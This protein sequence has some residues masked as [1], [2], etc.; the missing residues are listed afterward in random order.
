MRAVTFQGPREVAVTDVPEP[1]VEEPDDVVVET[2]LT[3]VCGSDLHLYHGDLPMEDGQVMGHE[4][5]GRVLEAGPEARGF[6]EGD[7]VVASF[8]VPCGA[9]PACRIGEHQAC[10]KLRLFGLGKPNG[11]LQGVQ[12][13]RVRVPRANLA[14]HHLP[15]GLPWHAGIFACDTLTAAYTG[16]RPRLRPGSTVA[17]VGAGPVGL[18]SLEVARALGAGATIAV[19]I[20][21]ARL[22]IAASRGHATV[23]PGHED[24]AAA[25]R[26][27]TDGVGAELVVEAVGGEGNGLATALRLVA[28]GGDVVSLGVPTARE[29]PIPLL[30]MFSRGFSLTSTMANVPRWIGEVLEFQAAGRLETDWLV[31]HRMSLEKAPEAYRLFDAHEAL[32]IVLTP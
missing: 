11:D 9:C 12:S 14:L 19:D 2:A 7:R 20:D 10:R 30:K 22:E 17:S 32:K 31:T 5:V 28:P 15:D 18:L 1:R 29:V 16:V 25:L 24:P 23:D 27:R 26:E 21:P 3:A 13:E 8:Q 6:G 4:L